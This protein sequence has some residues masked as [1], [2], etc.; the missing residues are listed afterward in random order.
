[1][2]IKASK[3]E[4]AEIRA[5]SVTAL[6]WYDDDAARS[7]LL[8]ALGDRDKSVRQAAVASLAFQPTGSLQ[9]WLEGEPGNLVPVQRVYAAR[10]LQLMN[11]GDYT[12]IFTRFLKEKADE[13]KDYPATVQATIGLRDAYLKRPVPES[14]E[15]LRDP[16][17][18]IRLAATLAVI[19]RGD[20]D[21]SVQLLEHAKEHY[22]LQLD[23][24]VSRQ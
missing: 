13:V 4:E 1:M 24:S 17:R 14:V 9:K 20:S 7:A 19:E 8:E 22:E 21:Q 3:P 11:G 12:E 10:A 2:M 6:R 5:A 15:A 18:E 23:A 16:R